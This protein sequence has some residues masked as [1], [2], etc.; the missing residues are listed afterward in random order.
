MAITAS[1][2]NTIVLHGKTYKRPTRPT[3]VVC[4][5]GFDPTYL[6]QGIA[7]GTLPTLA[8]F[9]KSGFHRTANVAMPSFTNPNNVSIITGVPT[10]V[11]GIAGNY[12]LDSATNTEHMV[13]D[14]SLLRGST[15][16]AEMAAQGVRVAAITA[17]DKLRRIIDHGLGL[18]VTSTRGSNSQNICFS[19]EKASD[20][21]LQQW[22]GRP[23]RPDQYSGDLSLCVLDA[24]IRILEAD[25]ADLFYLTLSDF[26]QHKH[27]PCTPAASEFMQGVDSRIGRLIELGAVVAVTGDHGMSDKS[28]DDGKPNVLFVQDALEAQFGLPSGSIRVI[29]PI[30]DPFVKHHGALGGFVRVHILDESFRSQ[31]P[32]MVEY[33]RGLPA[34]EAALLKEDAARQLEMPLDREGDFVV[35]SSKNYVVGGRAAEHDL[36]TLGGHRLRSHGGFS[37]QQV[38]LLMSVPI[39]EDDSTR[40][41][42]WR[43][44]SIFDLILNYGQ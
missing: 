9:V 19:T 30:T 38:P 2:K 40:F 10:A 34:V 29:C 4:V 26:I 1:T 35:V 32:A 44:F 39:V 33:L 5:D 11:H 27:A 8:G 22:I 43:N 37:E 15:I 24:G 16:L 41:R 18:G 21:E 42:Q 13:L 23:Q 7:D 36:S 3:V 20:A 25:R 12:F 6:E 17:K 14:D 31:A 28:C